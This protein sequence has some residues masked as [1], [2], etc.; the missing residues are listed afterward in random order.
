MARGLHH[1]IDGGLRQ[2]GAAEVGVQHGAGQ[3][4]HPAYPTLVLGGEAFA[5]AP[6]E[7]RLAQLHRRQ[8]AVAHWL[9][10]LVEQVAQGAQQRLAT[11]ALLQR[12][13]RRAAQQAIHRGQA[14]GGHPSPPG[15]SSRLGA[16][17]W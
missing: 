14:Q 1:R 11:V 4:E 2:Q 10:Q 3:V 17:R 15:A 5:D 6:G 9:A 13:H 7:H 8:L 16:W 12:R